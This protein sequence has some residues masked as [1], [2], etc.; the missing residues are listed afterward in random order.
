M[1]GIKGLGS[2]KDMGRVLAL[3]AL[4]VIR[5]GAAG[6]Q[7]A[8]NPFAALS[9]D[10]NEPI[11]IAANNVVAD[12]D[13]STA[14]YSGN[15]VVKQGEMLMRSD[16]LKIFAPKGEISRIEAAGNV[17]LSSPTGSAQSATAVYDVVPRVVTLN[18]GVI[19]THE[20]NVMRGS[21]LTVDLVSGE[22]K[23]I[24]ELGPQGKPGRV[25]GLFNPATGQQPGAA[26]PQAQGSAP[27][28]P[29]PVPVAKPA[30]E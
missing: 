15:V 16:T 21:G 24:G 28:Q 17:V 6:A 27:Q 2:R 3:A 14:T 29:L 7:S 22:A 13:A 30:R 5:G 20:D 19:L 1:M 18:G 23:L 4:L 10:T 8:P 12:F 11:N 25:R 26:A 9:K